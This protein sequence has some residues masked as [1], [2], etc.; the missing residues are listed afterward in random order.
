[1]VGTF[2]NL[3]YGCILGSYVGD[4]LG[5]H[6]E[7]ETQLRPEDFMKNCMTMPGGGPFMIDEG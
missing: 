5:S 1:M 6:N 3:V 2:E 4:S 7:F